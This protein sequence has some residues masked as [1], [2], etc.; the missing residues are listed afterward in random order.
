MQLKAKPVWVIRIGVRTV[1]AGLLIIAACGSL[2]AGEGT[3]AQRKACTPDVFRLCKEFIPNRSEIANC[4]ER[5]KLR[6]HA[7]CR[8]IFDGKSK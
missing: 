3:S 6:L 5:N 1:L 2:H 8:V 7:D 4:L